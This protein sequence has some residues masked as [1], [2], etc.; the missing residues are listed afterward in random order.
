MSAS[1]DT[2]AAR[3]N[4]MNA[5]IATQYTER[6]CPM[7]SHRRTLTYP[8]FRTTGQTG[9]GRAEIAVARGQTFGT[10]WS[11]EGPARRRH[12]NPISF[13]EELHESDLEVLNSG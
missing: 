4:A 3:T 7:E 5:F 12:D 10:V 6:R 11:A 9:R 8:T 1:A 2:K 13:L